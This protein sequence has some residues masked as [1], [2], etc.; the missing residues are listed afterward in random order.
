MKTITYLLLAFAFLTSQHTQAQYQTHAETAEEVEAL[1]AAEGLLDVR[2]F[3]YPN[4][5]AYFDRQTSTYLYSKNGKDWYEGSKLPSGLR[6]YSLSNGKRV[7]ITDYAGEEPFS[8]LEAHRKQFPANYSG[9][10]PPASQDASL[11]IN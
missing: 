11:A 4:L 8:Q 2:Y 5:E 9:K 6:G 7:P 1:M 3:Y 10:R